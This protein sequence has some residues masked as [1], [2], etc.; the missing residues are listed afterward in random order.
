MMK[1]TTYFAEIANRKAEKY[2][3]E[4]TRIHLLVHLLVSCKVRNFLC[5]FTE[6]CFAIFDQS[7]HT[8]FLTWYPE[9]YFY[10]SFYG[11][12]LRFKSSRGKGVHFYV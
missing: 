1:S 8:I 10:H 11:M 3:K 5:E 12:I 9:I 2:L 7:S 4:K 6:N